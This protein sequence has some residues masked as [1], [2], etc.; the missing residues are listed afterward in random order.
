MD[1]LVLLGFLELMVRQAQ[2]ESK[3][4]LELQD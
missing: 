4:M 3:E 1:R 2:L